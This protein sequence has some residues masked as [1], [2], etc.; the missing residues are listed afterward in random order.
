MLKKRFIQ[1][2]FALSYLKFPLKTLG[3]SLFV[4]IAL[5]ASAA[6]NSNSSELKQNL[7]IGVTP[8]KY[9]QETFDGWYHSD[10][11]A[12]IIS[13]PNYQSLNFVL[14]GES[15]EDSRTLVLIAKDY[16][17]QN[18]NKFGLNQKSISE[19]TVTSI[20]QNSDFSVVRLEQKVNGLSVYGSSIAITI[21]RNSKITFV[22]S[23]TITGIDFDKKMTA[24]QKEFI[25]L[26]KL[27]ELSK[28]E[29]LAVFKE[30]GYEIKL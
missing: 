29:L 6:S 13:E 11:T 27:D 20:R 3:L 10:G 9:L 2:V 1:G 14:S 30:L 7:S 24:L 25:E 17:T 8:Q 12:S 18:A 5:N 15:E 23:N 26:I 4:T 21:N 22:A 19:L 16:I 28:N